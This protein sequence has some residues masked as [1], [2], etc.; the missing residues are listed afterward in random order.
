MKQLFFFY[1]TYNVPKPDDWNPNNY[2]LEVVSNGPYSEMRP[3]QA[4]GPIGGM[5]GGSYAV[6]TQSD[7]MSS[8]MQFPIDI[9]ISNGSSRGAGC[10]IQRSGTYT[11]YCFAGLDIDSPWQQSSPRGNYGGKNYA[12]GGGGAGG[13]NGPGANGGTWQGG[14]ANGGTPYEWYDPNTGLI[15]QLG[16]GGDAYP[17]TGS[18]WGFGSGGPGDSRQTVGQFNMG[19]PGIVVISWEP[20]IT[21][22]STVAFM[23]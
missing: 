20:L 3:P 6:G 12:Y 2:V 11:Q 8:N 23:T 22:E 19:G 18:T 9:Y 7:Y 13:P 10:Y 4:P 16:D 5:W 14:K 15:H 1:T 17:Y 21:Q